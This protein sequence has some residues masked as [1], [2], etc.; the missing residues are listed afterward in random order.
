MKREESLDSTDES[1]DE[2]RSNDEDD[3]EEE[4]PVKRKKATRTSA[5]AHK[6]TDP[7]RSTTRGQTAVSG[8][9]STSIR[10]FPSHRR[11]SLRL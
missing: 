4:E 5:E 3:D 2:N 10:I 7:S 9:V 1:Q 11:S 6:T 8:N